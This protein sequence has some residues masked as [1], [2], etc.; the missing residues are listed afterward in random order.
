M[1]LLPLVVEV[2]SLEMPRSRHFTLTHAADKQVVLPLRELVAGVEAETRGRDRRHP[3]DDRRLHLFLVRLHAH[4]WSEVKAP[5]AQNR[6][7][8]VLP[9]TQD[10]HFVAAI[11]SIL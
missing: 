2:D 11:R 7:A 3:E 8:V 6:P 4:A 9:R 5:E 1:Q 10:V